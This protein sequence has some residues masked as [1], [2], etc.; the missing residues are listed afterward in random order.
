[1]DLREVTIEAATRLEGTTFQIT[2]ADGRTTTVTLDEVLPFEPANRRRS[3]PRPGPS[4]RAPFSM[5]F[6]GDP[7]IVLPQGMYTLRSD[8]ETF[9]GIF[10]VP[11]GNDGE[12]TQY[13]AV[14]T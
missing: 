4:P 7:G 2:L 9:E 14:F 11:V 5:Y 8:A 13:E 6:L 10:L 3:R 12:G 1:M